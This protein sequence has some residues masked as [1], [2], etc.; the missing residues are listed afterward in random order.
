MPQQYRQGDV[1]LTKLDK[2]PEG[3]TKAKN[4]VLALGEATGHKHLV[5]EGEVYVNSEGEL[6]VQA[7]E[8]TDLAHLNKVGAPADHDTYR[9]DEGWYAVGI[10]REWDP[11]QEQEAGR[12]ID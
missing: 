11:F 7:F 6:F 2:A 12:V 4:K 8:S 5:V 1:F 9:I 3:L 10:E